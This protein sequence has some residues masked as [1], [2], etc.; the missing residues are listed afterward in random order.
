MYTVIRNFTITEETPGWEKFISKTKAIF[1]SIPANWDLDIVRPPFVTN[2]M[3]IYQKGH[4]KIL[5]DF[6]NSDPCGR[7]RLN[8]KGA[9]EA[10]HELG[11]NFKENIFVLLDDGEELYIFGLVKFSAE[12]NI[13]VAEINWDNFIEQN[14][15]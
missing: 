3:T 7:V 14:I 6:Q 5:A 1:P 8:T 2:Q 11:E 10:I 9:L 4:P 13:W 15:S 12:E